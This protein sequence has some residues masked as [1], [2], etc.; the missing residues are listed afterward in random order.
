[1]VFAGLGLSTLAYV[2]SVASL[3]RRIRLND[4]VANRYLTLGVIIGII[5]YIPALYYQPIAA[6]IRTVP[7]SA[8]DWL[9]LVLFSGTQ[10]LVLEGIKAAY[11]KQK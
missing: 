10:I 3:E 4:L 2:F 1:M 7:L 8:W 11:H 6:I 9:I 5:L